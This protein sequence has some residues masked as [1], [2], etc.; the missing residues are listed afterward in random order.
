MEI[1]D[2]PDGLSGRERERV[3]AFETGNW[4]EA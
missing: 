3:V 1:D 4:F 2:G